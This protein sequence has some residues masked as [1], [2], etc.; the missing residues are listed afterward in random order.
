MPEWSERVRKAIVRSFILGA[1]RC[2][3]YVEPFLDA[4]LLL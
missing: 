3:L 4:T 1:A 2:D